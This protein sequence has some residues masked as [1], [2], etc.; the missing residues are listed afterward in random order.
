MEHSSTRSSACISQSINGSHTN[1]TCCL[2]FV[3]YSS[4]VRYTDI[5]KNFPCCIFMS[6]NIFKSEQTL[7]GISGSRKRKKKEGKKEEE[8]VNVLVREIVREKLKFLYST[9]HHPFMCFFLIQLY[10]T[11]KHH[12]GHY[13]I[14]KFL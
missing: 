7:S 4:R 14:I 3:S 12:L 13:E 9:T 11:F 10:F 2:F 6:L 8:Y 5:V 1:R